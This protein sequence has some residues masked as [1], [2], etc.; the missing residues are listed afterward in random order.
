MNEKLIQLIKRCPF[1]DLLEREEITDISYNGN[2]IFYMDSKSGRKKYE[3]E[4]NYD[5]IKDFIRDIANFLDQSFSVSSPILDVSFLNLR[6]NAIHD[7]ICKKNG[8]KKI[9]FSIRKFSSK[10]R[11]LNDGKFFPKE[12]NN[13]LDY[14]LAKKSSIV[15]TGLPG[16]GKTEFQKYLL[17]LFKNNERI[18]VIDSINELDIKTNCDTTF[19]IP[20]KLKFSSV[21]DLIKASLR[22]NPDYIVLAEAR[23][24]EFKN[25]Y[26]SLLTGL[27]TIT[28]LHSKDCESSLNRMVYLL[29]DKN[30]S[31]KEILNNL[32][33]HIDFIFNI[34][35]K[36]VNNSVVRYIKEIYLI[37]KSK[38]YL[39]Y[40]N[41]KTPQ[42][43]K[44][45]KE[46]ISENYEILK[47]M[48]V[49][50][51]FYE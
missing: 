43:I 40:S 27:S 28:T 2:E 42:I 38:N 11:I 3:K 51:V 33:E 24:K 30:N 22:L 48:N 17:T 44:L 41:Y 12:I 18:I 6:L 36:E 4:I 47:K 46:Y 15:I 14:I 26:E 31:E 13:F 25:V 50:E 34:D 35:K 9:C 7:S 49:S 23:G 20:E 10:I 5:I 21:E 1:L 19:L 16:S 45:P 37:Y 39:I 32:K 29:K 8:E